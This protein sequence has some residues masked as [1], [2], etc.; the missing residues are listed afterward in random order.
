M[1]I[2]KL[3]MVWGILP[4]SNHHLQVV[5]RSVSPGPERSTARIRVQ[6]LPCSK[7]PAWLIN[8]IPSGYLTVCHGKSPFLIGKP[9]ISMGHGFHGYVS[10]NQ[11]VV[12]QCFVLTLFQNPMICIWKNQKISYSH[13]ITW[14]LELLQNFISSIGILN[15]NH[16]AGNLTKII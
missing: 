11:R 12:P 8:D 1:V 16:L 15:P 10:H 6:T 5:L 7:I 9:S 3:M 14:I 4:S 2:P 13:A